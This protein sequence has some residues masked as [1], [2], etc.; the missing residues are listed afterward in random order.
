MVTVCSY[1]VNSNAICL[2]KNGCGLLC[3]PFVLEKSVTDCAIDLTES[4]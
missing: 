3:C 4:F 2:E 1:A